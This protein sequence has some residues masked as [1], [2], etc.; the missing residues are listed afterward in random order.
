M[1]KGW[2]ETSDLRRDSSSTIYAFN[3][4]TIDVPGEFTKS[5]E[6]YSL[7]YLEM[8]VTATFYT[9]IGKSLLSF[10]VGPYIS[11][12]LKG[13]YKYKVLNSSKTLADSSAIIS[14]GGTKNKPIYKANQ[15]DYGASIE[16]SMEFRMGV[17]VNATYTVGVTN[18][19]EERYGA[20]QNRHRV[21]M[22]SLGYYMKKK[23]KSN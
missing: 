13:K 18:V 2:I 17:N 19:I 4:G 5:K 20:L 15:F 14:F 7:S 11:Y 8:P 6:T 12:G 9:P 16:A 10:G 22:L 3:I 21:I 23:R 1:N